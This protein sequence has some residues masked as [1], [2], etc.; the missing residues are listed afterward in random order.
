[1]KNM[2]QINTTMSPNPAVNGFTGG[3]GAS[4][5]DTGGGISTKDILA[6]VLAKLKQ[7]NAEV[8]QAA[9]KVQGGGGQAGGAGGAGGTG[10]TQGN[11]DMLT[12]QQA[13]TQMNTDNSLGTNMIQGV[14]DTQKDTA[15]ATH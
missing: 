7:D 1:M 4:T 2:S 12:L 9:Q 5:M 8:S 15:K 13:V 6:A 11:A 3:Q 10:D 14:G